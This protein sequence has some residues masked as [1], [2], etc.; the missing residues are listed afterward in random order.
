[1]I[2][3]RAARSSPA[4]AA[5]RSPRRQRRPAD[6]AVAGPARTARP[7]AGGQVRRP[8]AAVSPERDLRPGGRR[9]AS[10]RRSPTGSDNRAALLRAAGRRPR[11]ACAGRRRAACRRHA[12][13]GARTRSRQDQHR[14][15]LGLSARRAA[16]CQHDPACGALP[17]Q[18]RPPGRASARRISAG[19]AACCRPTALGRKNALFAGSDKLAA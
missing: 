11:P 18:P 17:L 10:A 4:A 19:S 15:A 12:G 1:M 13:A 8:P 3:H 2:R 9:P 16:A 7:C 5:R 14:P 6:R